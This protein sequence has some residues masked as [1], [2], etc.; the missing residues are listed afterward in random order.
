MNA[1]DNIPREWW[2]ILAFCGVVALVIAVT[3]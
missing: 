2:L 1:D 3:T